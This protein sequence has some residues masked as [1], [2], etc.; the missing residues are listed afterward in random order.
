MDGCLFA[1]PP[2]GAQVLRG[3]TPRQLAAVEVEGGGFALRWEELDADLT[4]SG[5]LAGRFGSK[6]WMSELG[7]A[8]GR[9]RSEKKA[10]AVRANG[11]KGGRPR[12][13]AKAS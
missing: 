8:G 2:E 12:R 4:V 7:R 13:P 6:R 11:M 3:A 1:F 9:A 10:R 5:L